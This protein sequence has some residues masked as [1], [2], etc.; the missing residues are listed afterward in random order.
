VRIGVV[1]NGISLFKDVFYKEYFPVLSKEFELEVFET[2][3]VNDGISIAKKIVHRGFDVIMPAG[4]DG[5][6]H[7]VVNGLLSDAGEST[8]VPIM[9]LLPLGSGNDFARTLAQDFSPSAIVE[10]LKKFQTKEIDVGE[11]LFAV[12]PAQNKTASLQSKRFFVNVVDVGMGPIVV[13]GVLDSGRAFGSAVAYYQSI[14]KTFFTYKPFRLYAKGDDWE[15]TNNVRTFAIG[16]AKYFGNGLCIAPE[17]LL[18]DQVFNIF[19]CGKV[20]V[21]DFIIHTFPLKTGRKVRH[22]EVTYY[23]ATKVSLSSDRPAEIE[24]DGEIIGWL[25][26]KINFASCR[27]SILI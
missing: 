4:G 23:K 15:W 1:L 17:A 5:T 16:N 14:V 20:S 8:R 18:D 24:A 21:L 7:Q 26:A 27:L 2:R 10:R 9:A 12:S 19:A 3:T 6:I 11:V 25:P 13:R 22:P